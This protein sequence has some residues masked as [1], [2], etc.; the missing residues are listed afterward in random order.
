MHHI[1]PVM[2][3]YTM[4]ICSYYSLQNKCRTVDPIR[5]NL[6]PSGKLSF[7]IIYKFWQNGASVRQVSDLILKT[8]IIKGYYNYKCPKTFLIWTLV[9]DWSQKLFSDFKDYKWKYWYKYVILLILKLKYV[10]AKSKTLL[11]MPWLLD[12][13]N[14]FWCFFKTI[15]HLAMGYQLTVWMF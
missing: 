2:S 9:L 4:S 1:R 12:D 13:A 8:V 15:Q 6:D 3:N 5:Q 14:K 7:F 10:R 11:L